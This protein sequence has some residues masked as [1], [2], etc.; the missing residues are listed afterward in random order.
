ME[1]TLKMKI[2]YDPT[3]GALTIRLIEEPMECEVIH[4]AIL[5]TLGIAPFDRSLQMSLKFSF[6]SST[7]SPWVQ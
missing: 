7:V 4:S 3:V 5:R 6:S 2:V 1:V